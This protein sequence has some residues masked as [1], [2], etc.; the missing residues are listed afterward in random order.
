M[1]TR[2]KGAAAR[3]ILSAMLLVSMMASVVPSASAASLSSMSLTLSSSQPDATGVTHTFAFTTATA[4]TVKGVEFEYC[5]TGS[6]SCTTPT[7]LSTTGAA[8]D[9]GA[10]SP[11][12]FDT[13][14]IDVSTNGLVAMTDTT[15]YADS[16][17]AIGEFELVLDIADLQDF[18]PSQIGSRDAR[19][20]DATDSLEFTLF[21]Q[22]RLRLRTDSVYVY[23][24]VDAE[25]PSYYEV[26][27][28]PPTLKVLE[29]AINTNESV[30]L[31]G[32]AA[33]LTEVVVVISGS[34]QEHTVVTGL[35]GF[36]SVWLPGPWE[37]GG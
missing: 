23:A 22:D 1:K 33:P 34:L 12:D 21:A 28:M 31:A 32:S 26:P 27:L 25:G 13:F 11:N 20:G 18:L 14:S 6:G 15:G 8:I 3:T 19:I 35:N 2:S 30:T 16:A 29:P 36:W 4:G 17:S 37:P 24:Q 7:G 10:T 5:T 9:T